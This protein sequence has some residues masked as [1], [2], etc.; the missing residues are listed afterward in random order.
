VNP[1]F[2]GDQFSFATRNTEFV[3]DDFVGGDYTPGTI[4]GGRLAHLGAHKYIPYLTTIQ[5]DWAT[6]LRQFKPDPSK[7]MYD[8]CDAC[9]HERK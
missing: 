5:N 4:K 3:K 7:E 6:L 9:Q 1:P 2:R 8:S